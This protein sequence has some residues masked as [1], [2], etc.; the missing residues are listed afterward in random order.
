MT[1]PPRAAG[2][3]LAEGWARKAY[4]SGPG[5]S[6]GLGDETAGPW[7]EAGGKPCGLWGL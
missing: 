4:A 2:G 3:R 5:D 7:A 6:L 1:E